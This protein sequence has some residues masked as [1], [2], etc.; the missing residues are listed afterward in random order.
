MSRCRNGGCRWCGGGGS[1]DSCS[2]KWRTFHRK[3]SSSLAT[4]PP[5]P[6]QRTNQGVSKIFREQTI[7]VKGDGIIGYLE[8]IRYG[9]EH[10]KRKILRLNEGKEKRRQIEKLT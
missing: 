4:F 10:L 5:W 9:T 7:D 6:L 1:S 3:T 2:G 8:Q